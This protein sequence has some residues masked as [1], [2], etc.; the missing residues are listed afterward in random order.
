MGKIGCKNDKKRISK[1]LETMP[2]I[3]KIFQLDV[4]PEKFLDACS[5]DELIE[6]EL[7]LGSSKYQ[8]KIVDQY[9]KL[10]A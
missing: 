5:S 6:L 4:T 7:L 2:K 10:N 3:Q 8:K 1:K 9:I